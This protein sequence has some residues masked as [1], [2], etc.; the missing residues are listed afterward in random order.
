[1]KEKFAS[2]YLVAGATDD[3]G[4]HGAGRIVTG[5]AGLAHTGA[6]VNDKGCRKEGERTERREHELRKVGRARGDI[7]HHLGK[8]DSG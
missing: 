2:P 7:H 1:M 4:E 8:L 3:G 5:E 6:I